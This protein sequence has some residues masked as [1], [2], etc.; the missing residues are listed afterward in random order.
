M[1]MKKTCEGCHW[2]EKVRGGKC[3]LFRVRS[4]C[5]YFIYRQEGKKKM[6][7]KISELTNEEYRDLAE[8]WNLE[9]L[10]SKNVHVLKLNLPSREK[11]I[12]EIRIE[13]KKI[14]GG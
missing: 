13:I 12:E 2:M 8:L 14:E 6:V 5:A 3:R 9:S 11:L 1:E 10:L 4:A 7:K